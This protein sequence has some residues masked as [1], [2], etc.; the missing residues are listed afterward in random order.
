M[1][2]CRA[3]MTSRSGEVWVETLRVCGG[4]IFSFPQRS[5]QGV[6]NAKAVHVLV[7]TLAK[8][9][10]TARNAPFLLAKKPRE[11]G[12][13]NHYHCMILYL[14]MPCIYIYRYTCHI[15]IYMSCVS[16]IKKNGFNLFQM[17]MHIDGNIT[18]LNYPTISNLGRLK[19]VQY[20]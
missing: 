19:R 7:E 14:Y 13:M 5:L 9:F 15:Y 6:L 2:L 4:T 3:M 18:G 1:A 17:D 12:S 8:V 10:P 11:M 16:V 20:M